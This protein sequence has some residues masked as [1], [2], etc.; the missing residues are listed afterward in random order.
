MPGVTLSRMDKTETPAATW[1]LCWD[2][3]SV[4]P[5]RFLTRLAVLPPVLDGW[6]KLASHDRC[7]GLVTLDGDG[8]PVLCRA[9]CPWPDPGEVT[10]RGWQAAEVAGQPA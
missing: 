3:G 6:A 8:Y 2:D 1:A 7:G 4:E 9:G 10:M 5:R